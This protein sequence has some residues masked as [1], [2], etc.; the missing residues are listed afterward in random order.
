IPSGLV[1][2]GYCIRR[3]IEQGF[4]SYDFLRGNE[5]YKYSYGVEETAIHCVLVK[6]R[7]GRNLGDRLDP[8]SVGSVL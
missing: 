1:L 3:A 5:A 4:R 7:T 6:T 8:R 2:H